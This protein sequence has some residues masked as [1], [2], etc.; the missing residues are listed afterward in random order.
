MALEGRRR[1]SRLLE[2]GRVPPVVQVLVAWVVRERL[3]QRHRRSSVEREN[4]RGGNR[5]SGI[6]AGISPLSRFH[7]G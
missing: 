4:G 5:R 3:D 1:I 7:G 2:N 6:Q